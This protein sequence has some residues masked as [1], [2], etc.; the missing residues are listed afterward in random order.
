MARIAW[1]ADRKNAEMDQIVLNEDAIAEKAS[2]L[3]SL[4]FDLQ[5][6]IQQTIGEKSDVQQ[7][8]QH[9]FDSGLLSKKESHQAQAWVK[10][11]RL[12]LQELSLQV[13]EQLRRLKEEHPEI[14]IAAELEDAISELQT[15]ISKAKE[16]RSQEIIQNIANLNIDSFQGEWETI[17][18]EQPLDRRLNLIH[19]FQK[20][21]DKQRQF[22]SIENISFHRE[23]R[24]S[25]SDLQSYEGK[26]LELS[27]FEEALEN[28]RNQTETHALDILFQADFSSI[29]DETILWLIECQNNR[30]YLN[31][32][33]TCYDDIDHTKTLEPRF[34]ELRKR[35]GK[36]CVNGLDFLL[37]TLQN[38]PK[39]HQLLQG[40]S[41]WEKDQSPE[42]IEHKKSFIQENEERLQTLMDQIRNA[43]R[44]EI[45]HE[46]MPNRRLRFDV[47]GL[48]DVLADTLEINVNS[49]MTLTKK[50]SS[51]QDLDHVLSGLKAIE[52]Q[53]IEA[54]KTVRQDGGA[55]K[56]LSQLQKK[57][58]IPASLLKQLEHDLEENYVLLDRLLPRVSQ[59]LKQVTLL[60]NRFGADKETDYLTITINDK[61]VDRLKGLYDFIDETNLDDI[62]RFCVVYN[63]KNRLLNDLFDGIAN[64]DLAIPKELSKSINAKVIKGYQEKRF[65]PAQLK[66]Q[67]YLQ[68]KDIFEAESQLICHTL[69]LVKPHK[70]RAKA[71]YKGIISVLS[72]AK[73]GAPWV[74]KKLGLIWGRLQTRMHQFQPHN[75]KRN[76]EGNRTALTTDVREMAGEKFDLQ[77]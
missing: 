27:T 62:K 6:R 61:D 12:K 70:V 49:L 50:A 34:K 4:F 46:E 33:K 16:S 3:S 54:Q 60:Q 37:Q 18:Q 42:E 44:E 39:V 23:I 15:N 32:R 51:V 76:F 66:Y 41:D 19:S 13:Y 30:M 71:A 45:A 40:L 5:Q 14:V 75:H 67:I 59:A 11:N 38:I 17:L 20:K 35:S 9:D 58:N 1:D 22:I 43:L 31:I 74:I 57:E 36:D 25:F 28:L 55:K 2:K 56:K 64:K 69:N 21:I 8:V 73:D 72:L 65:I 26:I 47:F 10:A 77:L 68:Y 53:I 52:N 48:S 7:A 24:D 63:L 29:G